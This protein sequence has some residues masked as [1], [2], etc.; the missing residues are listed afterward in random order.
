MSISVAFLVLICDINM[1]FFLSNTLLS[2]EINT[3]LTIK[4]HPMYFVVLDDEKPNVADLLVTDESH[5]ISIRCSFR[6]CC[7]VL[8]MTAFE[9]ICSD[10]LCGDREVDN[11][12]LTFT[13]IIMRRMRS[14]FQTRTSSFYPVVCRSSSVSDT[15]GPPSTT[16]RWLPRHSPSCPFRVRKRSKPT[17]TACVLDSR[18]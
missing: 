16:T 11:V 15:W 5:V 13:S 7:R 17:S 9:R 4:D 3:M 18:V 8:R 1:R 14:A 10:G 6:G 2:T 12:I